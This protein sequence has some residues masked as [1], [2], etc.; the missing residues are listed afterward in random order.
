MFVWGHFV[1]SHGVHAMVGKGLTSMRFSRQGFWKTHGR[2][3][4][5]FAYVGVVRVIVVMKWFIS[6]FE[7]YI[8]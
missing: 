4:R 1:A 7:R 2:Q 3:G 5:G 8:A 6:V